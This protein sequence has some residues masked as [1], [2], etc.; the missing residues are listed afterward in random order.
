MTDSSKHTSSSNPSRTFQEDL[1]QDLRETAPASESPS[2]SS[3]PRVTGTPARD[4]R[5]KAPTVELR[6]TP[7]RWLA[8][9]MRL[10]T[11]GHQRVVLSAGPVSVSVDLTRR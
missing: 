3:R 1:L 5:Q 9:S 4:V 6:V 8:P 2:S 11:R 10:A 7:T